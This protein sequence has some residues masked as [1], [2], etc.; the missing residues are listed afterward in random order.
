MF[1]QLLT[2]PSSLARLRAELDEAATQ[3]RLSEVATWKESIALP[4]LNACFKEA[5]RIHPPFGLHL[6]RVVP[7]GGLEVC[8]Q[9]LPAGC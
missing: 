9:M 2:N 1:Y 6:E 8:G 4:Y 5:G 7:Q 3:G